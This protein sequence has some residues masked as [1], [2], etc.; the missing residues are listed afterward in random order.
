VLLIACVPVSPVW[1][2]R[3]KDAC[4]D[5]GQITQNLKGSIDDYTHNHGKDRRIWSRALYQPRDLYV[6][7]PPCYNPFQHYPLMLWLHGFGQDEKSFVTDV[8]PLLDQAM[9]E[10]RLPPFIVAA[11]DGSLSGEPSP[12]FGGS[13]FLN[14]LAG[15]YEDYLLQDV[16]DFVVTKYRILPDRCAHI[17][18]GAS[19]GGFAAFNLGI[20][21]RECFGI[22]IGVH[23][24]VNLRWVDKKGHYFANFDPKN[25]G[26]RC[27]VEQGHEVIAR[28]Y[29]G[30][31][32]I[33]LKHVIDP[34]FGRDADA[35]AA[36]SRENPIEMIDRLKLCE[37]QLHMYVAYGGKDQFN[38][39]AQAE[40]FLYLASCR[41]ICVGVGYEPNGRHDYA[42]AA[43]LFP[44]I[45]DWLTPL[46]AP[47]CPAGTG[48]EAGCACTAPEKPG[49]S[50]H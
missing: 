38:I 4:T 15:A 5:L 46:L 37:G 17:I 1:A 40:S 21:H 11:P 44:G 25:W 32:T 22:V 33:R 3:K 45:V 39:D 18:A 27:T 42:T 43:K 24:P 49:K 31:V 9:A 35:L 16:W 41:G 36:V 19:M 30:V 13:F 34:L 26:W 7:L 2:G 10:G 50:G 29:G 14:S 8:A 20:K 48:E 28:F 47:Y 23:P 12:W 6:Y